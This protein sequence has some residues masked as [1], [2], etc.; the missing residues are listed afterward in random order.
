MLLA[1]LIV[2]ST[3]ASVTWAIEP[4]EYPVTQGRIDAVVQGAGAEVVQRVLSSIDSANE[5][6]P[7]NWSNA[8]VNAGEQF[9][10]S[11]DAMV[12]SDRPAAL[13][14]Y[15]TAQSLYRLGFL[16]EFYSAPERKAYRKFADVMTKINPLL[17]RPYTIETVSYRD[18]DVRVHLYVPERAGEKP[19]L[20]L[21]TGGVD[22]SKESGWEA[23]QLLAARGIALAAF[24]L[25]GTGENAQWTSTPDSHDLHRKILDHF[26]E[27]GEFDFDKVG[28]IGGSF[29]GYYVIKLANEEPRVKAAVN[30][31]GLVHSAFSTPT[32]VVTRL[33]Q[34]PEGDV[35]RSFMRRM[36]LNPEELDAELG[37]KA[38]A[39]SLIDSGYLENLRILPP[40]LT[41]NGGRDRVVSLEDMKLVNSRAE[42]GELWVLGL[43]GHCASEYMPVA[44]PQ[45]MDWLA[46]KLHAETD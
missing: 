32:Q 40:M 27:S 25:V 34:T 12:S 43:A 15:F 20:V 26:E 36:G 39:F 38:R 8:W 13:Q 5:E 33:I 14:A 23:G 10:V 2:L 4:H 45:M 1:I 19:P 21:Y 7:K 6:G 29:G 37:P 22:G 17:E 42:N 30:H 3:A 31:C 9:E 18:A 11:A 16:P 35:F 41:V 46:T 28:L 24:D 44:Y